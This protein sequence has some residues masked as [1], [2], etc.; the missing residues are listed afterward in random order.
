MNLIN[1]FLQMKKHSSFIVE[2]SQITYLNFGNFTTSD[3]M[4]TVIMHN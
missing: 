2:V 4:Q 3:C 1:I